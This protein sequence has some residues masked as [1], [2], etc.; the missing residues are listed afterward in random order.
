MSEPLDSFTDPTQPW[1]SKKAELERFFKTLA[2]TVAVDF[3]GVLHPYTE[4]WVGSTPADEPPM[5]GAEDFLRGITEVGYRVIVFS[6]RCDHE[7]GMEGTK[8]WLEKWGLMNYIDVVTC[9]KPAAVA[10]VDD[11]AVPFQGDWEAVV[12]G[13]GRLAGGRA[14]GAAHE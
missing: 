3:D 12:A 10:Y 8:M 13:I 5:A 1:L 11:R 9:Q 14:H 4:G 6:T 2:R 7:K